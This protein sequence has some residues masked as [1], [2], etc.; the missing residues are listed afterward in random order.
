MRFSFGL[1]CA[2]PALALAQ[3]APAAAPTPA[4]GLLQSVLGLAVVV[5]AI[6]AFAWLAKRLSQPRGG[7]TSLLKLVASL[8]VGAK[9]RVAVV[10]IADTW[11]VVGV[12]AN[13]VNAL[14]TLPKGESSIESVQ[15]VHSFAQ[16]LQGLK[17]K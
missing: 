4:S 8:P 5:V 6:L 17:R 1:A 13:Q 9:E 14:H 10:E 11:I 3:Q 7:R 15:P 12:T 16:V 2:W